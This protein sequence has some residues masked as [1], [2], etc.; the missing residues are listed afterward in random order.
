MGDVL[1]GW[2]L[3][4]QRHDRVNPLQMWHMVECINAKAP[5]PGLNPADR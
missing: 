5:A 3:L 2:P 4:M 1:D